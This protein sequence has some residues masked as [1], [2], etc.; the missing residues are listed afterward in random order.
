[1]K[2]STL[3]VA[4][5]M[6]LIALLASPVTQL[7]TSS[8]L[9]TLGVLMIVLS[10]GIALWAF[11]SMRPGTFTVMPEPATR[12]SLTQ[13]GPYRS[14]RHPMYSAALLGGLGA[15][16]SHM[17]LI[18]WFWLIALAALLTVKLLR[19]ESY[20][21]QRYEEYASYKARTYALLPFVY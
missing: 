8:L 20:L 6:L 14:V 2:I 11:V 4:G 7:Y 13:A 3:L 1:M 19:E 21:T 15:A 17:N 18:H 16:L 10:I 12:A 9:S 5:Q